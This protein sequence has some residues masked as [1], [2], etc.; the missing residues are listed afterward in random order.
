MNCISYILFILFFFFGSLLPT[1]KIDEAAVIQNMTLVST[2]KDQEV[3]PKVIN[4]REDNFLDDFLPK[5]PFLSSPKEKTL[6]EKIEEWFWNLWGKIC[7][8]FRRN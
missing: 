5:G 3:H 8:L 1:I 4:I 6:L 7:A 2:H